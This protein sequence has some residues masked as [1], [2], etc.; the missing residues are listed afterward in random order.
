VRYGS[1]GLGRALDRRTA[2]AQDRRTAAGHRDPDNPP[3][4]VDALYQV[5]LQC[6]YMS[7]YTITVSPDTKM[8]F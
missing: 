7:P 8:V 3:V 2:G 4:W 1:S 6:C 5:W